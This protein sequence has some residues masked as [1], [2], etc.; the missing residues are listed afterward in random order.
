M[1]FSLGRDKRINVKR[2]TMKEKTSTKMIGS[3]RER[4]AA[5]K[6]TVKN[7]KLVPIHIRIEDQYPVSQNSQIEVKP[8]ENSNATV[9]ALTGKLTW[10]M[11][12]APA[13]SKVVNFSFTAKYP[14]DKA[15]GGL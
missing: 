4:S 6:I 8:G 11:D 2:E 13:E 14:K 9:D 1:Q 3:N 12:L 5:Y 10:T 7:N 15:I